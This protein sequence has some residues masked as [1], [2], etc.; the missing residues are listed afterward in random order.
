MNYW[1]LINLTNEEYQVGLGANYRGII[2]VQTWALGKAEVMLL[3]QSFQTND[4]PCH[5]DLWTLIIGQLF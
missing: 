2:R 5:F 3:E 1:N 4:Y